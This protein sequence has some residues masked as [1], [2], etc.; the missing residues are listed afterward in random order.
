[1]NLSHREP[2]T[3][4]ADDKHPP[5]QQQEP[6]TAISSH[7]SSLCTMPMQEADLKDLRLDLEA[8]Q[9]ALKI[10]RKKCDAKVRLNERNNV[11][12]ALEWH[13]AWPC[14]AGA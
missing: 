6:V 9:E 2:E 13:F 1:M 14:N 7:N 4:L 3:C 10:S 8:H 5:M 12:S 11:R